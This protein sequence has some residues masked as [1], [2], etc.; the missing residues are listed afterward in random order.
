[1]LGACTYRP[2]F[3]G[4]IL[5][6]LCLTFSLSVSAAAAGRLSPKVA[7][8]VSQRIRP[9][10]EAL[11]GLRGALAQTSE[12]EI[13]E[14]NLDSFKGKDRDIL[15]KDLTEGRFDLLIAIGPCA[16]HFVWA[17]FPSKDVRKL[18]T[19]VLSPEKVL[20]SAEQACGIAL[21]IP[22]QTQ[23]QLLSSVFP[24]ARRVGILYDPLCN[25]RF[26]KQAAGY[27]ADVGL[28]IVPLE[29]SSGKDI[30]LVLRHHWKDVD[31]LLLIP[32][33]TVI[34]ESLVQHIIKEA[35]LN[36][37]AVIGYNRFFYK[38]GAALAFVLDY[39]EIGRQTARIALRMLS[40]EG[41]RMESPVFHAWLN[42]RVIR[43]LGI[44]F[45][46]S[47]VAPLEWGP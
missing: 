28:C 36:R 31:T 39:Q 22:A 45:T 23:F 34:S 2:F 10:L 17:N 5:T 29:V 35:I 43:K 4:L 3:K 25:D 14:F 1:M 47:C 38:S 7:I 11:E 30:S 13:D 27:A 37:V 19:M 20:A 6:V 42:R 21:G 15:V 16:A 46:D 41:C 24:S 8:V 18:Y 26:V 33:R 12:A 32:D 9:Y 44:T 40:G